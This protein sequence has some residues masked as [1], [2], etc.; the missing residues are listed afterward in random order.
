GGTAGGGARA[1]RP[2]AGTRRGGGAARPL[3]GGGD[4]GGP[5]LQL[6]GLRLPG[7]GRTAQ[8]PRREDRSRAAADA[9][10]RLPDLAAPGG[11]SPRRG[12]SRRTRR[13][14][15]RARGRARSP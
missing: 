6:T 2:R 8:S 4:R 1:R 12:R 10:L 7:G 11:L 13:D 15:T 14:W 9:G 5:G 3:L